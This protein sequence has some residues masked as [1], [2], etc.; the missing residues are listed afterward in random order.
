MTRSR[1]I[2]LLPYETPRRPDNSQLFT[3][4]KI[5]TIPEDFRVHHTEVKHDTLAPDLDC[6]KVAILIAIKSNQIFK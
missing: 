3:G 6:T 1:F 2:V 4:R 5:Y